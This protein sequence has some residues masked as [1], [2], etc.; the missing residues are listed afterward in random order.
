MNKKDIQDLL[1]RILLSIIIFFFICFVI[2]KN[3]VDNDI[4]LKNSLDFSYIRSKSRFLFGQSLLKKDTYVTSEKIK[5]QKIEEYKN[6][7]RLQVDRNYV[8]KNIKSGVVIFIGNTEFADKTI[9]IESEDGLI[10]S[11]ANLENISVNM[12][13]YI[14]GN[15]ILGCVVDNNFYISFEKNKEYLTYEEYL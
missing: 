5:Y 11:Y 13:D 4:I 14:D 10:I 2:D 7:Y 1:N 6:G 12:Y 9:K 3:I 15:K 8:I